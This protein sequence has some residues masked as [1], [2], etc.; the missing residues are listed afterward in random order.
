MNTMRKLYIFLLF[1]S[2][3]FGLHSQTIIKI[4]YFFDIDPGYGNGKMFVFDEA[5]LVEIDTILPIDHL[6]DGFHVFYMR[7]QRNL[8]YWGPTLNY[9]FFK[10]RTII[11]GERDITLLEYFIDVDPGYG[12]GIEIPYVDEETVNYTIPL[13]A[14]SDGFHQVYFRA[15]NIDDLWS[16]L[17]IKPFLK[18]NYTDTNVNIDLIEYYFDED[19]GFGSGNPIDFIQADTINLSFEADLTDLN[20]G[21]HTISIRAMNE[22][23]NWSSIYHS[24]FLKEKTATNEIVKISKLEYFID[25]DPG[26]GNGIDILLDSASYAILKE[27]SADLEGY[28]SGDHVF[29]VRAQDENGN[30]SIVYTE[31]FE[32][33]TTPEQANLPTGDDQLCINSENTEYSTNYFADTITYEWHLLPVEAGTISGTDTVATV[34]WN[35]EFTGIAQIFVNAIN[36]CSIGLS[37]DTIEVTV[38]PYPV[39]SA[40]QDT[41][42]CYGETINLVAT[43]GTDYL[44][45]TEETNDTISVSPEET[46]EYSVTVIENDCSDIAEVT[47]TVNPVYFIEEEETICEGESYDWQGNVYEEAGTFNAEYTS[48]FGCDSIYQLDLTIDPMPIAGFT[49]ETNELEVSFTNAST[50]VSSYLWDFGDGNTETIENPVYNYASSGD[51]SVV[52]T[53]YSEFCDEATDTQMISVSTGINIIEFGNIGKI[54]PNPSNGLFYFEVNNHLNNDL[55]VQ[56]SNVNGQVVYSNYHI[57]KSIEKIDLSSHTKGIY[58]IQV[59]SDKY[60]RTEKIIIE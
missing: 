49:Y 10:D 53:S 17:L 52:L 45:S 25:D 40:G 4:E 57:T 11:P 24:S 38:F 1:F 51:Y 47:V 9:P 37:S 5:E 59:R 54:Y 13:N 42:I 50:N 35:E 3:T 27:F 15:L 8:N 18:L 6:E 58:F 36:D 55:F 20:I 2:F 12:N 46:T 16:Q 28:E 21:F 48:E 29:Y 30:W 31:E 43:G 56:I 44:W 39:A 19:P 7:S 34:D 32:V 14:L 22:N 41:S 26:F 33:C 23:G 60:S